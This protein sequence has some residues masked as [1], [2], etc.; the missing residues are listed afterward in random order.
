MT[1]TYATS[2]DVH[3]RVR[4]G[5][6]YA[7]NWRRSA[8]PSTPI[9]SWGSPSRLV[10]RLLRALEATGNRPHSCNGSTP[11]WTSTRSRPFAVVNDDVDRDREAETQRA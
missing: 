3:P 11:R 7:P 1:A 8:E 6:P 9:S 2:D 5:S 10:E 4:P